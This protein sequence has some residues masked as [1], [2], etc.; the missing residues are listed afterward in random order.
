M[1]GQIRPRERSDGRKRQGPQRRGPCGVVQV[2]R[3]FGD[4]QNTIWTPVTHPSHDPRTRYARSGPTLLEAMD[5]LAPATK[6]LA[7]ARAKPLRLFVTDVT[8]VCA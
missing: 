8:Q 3:V 7:E 2:R 6:L 1:N 4:I 5:E